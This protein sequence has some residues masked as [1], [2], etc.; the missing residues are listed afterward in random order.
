MQEKKMKMWCKKITVVLLLAFVLASSLFAAEFKSLPDFGIMG[1]RNVSLTDYAHEEEITVNAETGSTKE[2]KVAQLR[3]ILELILEGIVDIRQGKAEKKAEFSQIQ[4]AIQG[5]CSLFY[6]TD[7]E[8]KEPLHYF[9]QR[10]WRIIQGMNI[11]GTV[12]DRELEIWEQE[13]IL[14]VDRDFF[15]F[16]VE[17][18]TGRHCRVDLCRLLPKINGKHIREYINRILVPSDLYKQAITAAETNGFPGAKIIPHNNN[19]AAL[20]PQTDTAKGERK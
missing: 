19:Y 6:F 20:K 14:D 15:G 16:E 1:G 5:L 18:R 3:D 8:Y 7:D 4:G 11:E 10:E 9:R 17:S 2:I 12:Q 13:A